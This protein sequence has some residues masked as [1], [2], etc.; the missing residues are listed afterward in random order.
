MKKHKEQWW[1]HELKAGVVVQLK[2]EACIGVAYDW[3]HITSWALKD[4]DYATIISVQLAGN[5]FP[6]TDILHLALLSD[7]QK[8]ID[9]MLYRGIEMKKFMRLFDLTKC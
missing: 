4:S 1:S 8:T 2:S 3:L 7:T 5:T 9:I 6:Q